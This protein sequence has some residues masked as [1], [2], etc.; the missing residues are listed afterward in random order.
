MTEEFKALHEGNMATL[1]AIGAMYM[2]DL[3]TISKAQDYS[4]QQ[5][6]DLISLTEA[7]GVREVASQV[8]PGGPAPANK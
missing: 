2:G 6:K 1:G 7:V 4:F 5:G 8:S 3:K